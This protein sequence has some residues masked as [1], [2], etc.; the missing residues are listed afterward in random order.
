MNKVE[1]RC[2]ADNTIMIWVMDSVD[3][4]IVTLPFISDKQVAEICRDYS[5]YI[6][7][8]EREE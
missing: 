7:I 3:R 8:D 4:V 2:F 1:I 6:D 5:A